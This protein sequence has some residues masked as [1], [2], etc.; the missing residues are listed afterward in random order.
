MTIVSVT[1]TVILGPL[2]VD[3]GVEGQLGLDFSTKD[4]INLINDLDPTFTADMK[5]LAADANGRQSFSI[6][7]GGGASAGT[8]DS[9]NFNLSIPDTIAATKSAAAKAAKFISGRRQAT[10]LK[11]EN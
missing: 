6:A 2:N 1:V 3:V 11:E 4:G 7:G 9:L 5:G 8:D 10:R